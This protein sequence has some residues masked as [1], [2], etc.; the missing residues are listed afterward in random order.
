LKRLLL[1]KSRHSWMINESILK[2]WRGIDE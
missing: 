1:W 2:E